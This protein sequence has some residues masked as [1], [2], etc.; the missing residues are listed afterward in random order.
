[1]FLF[2]HVSQLQL[3]VV[4]ARRVATSAEGKHTVIEPVPKLVEAMLD[5]VFRRSEIEPGINYIV[6]LA[7]CPVQALANQ[8]LTLVDDALKAN[9]RE[10]TAAHSG[11]GNQAEN[12]DSEQAPRIWA[13]R[14][15]Q[16]LAFLCSSHVA[17]REVVE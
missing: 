6:L 2:H 4:F 1:M 7:N 10:Q 17:N 15:L 8:L 12:N 9:H 16:E 5:E 14:L 13:A 11:A 3:L